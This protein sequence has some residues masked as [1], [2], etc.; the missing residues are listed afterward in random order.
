MSTGIPNFVD[1][2][3][4]RKIVIENYKYL[5]RN[6]VRFMT[7]KEKNLRMMKERNIKIFNNGDYLQKTIFY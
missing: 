6:K 2:W 3:V 5:T 7:C 4:C 1:N